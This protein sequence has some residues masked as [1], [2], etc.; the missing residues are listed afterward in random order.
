MNIFHQ[1]N[2]LPNELK[3]DEFGFYISINIF[4]KTLNTELIFKNIRNCKEKEK[5][6]HE[7]RSKIGTANLMH[8]SKVF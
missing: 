7:A 1:K 8:D 4:F 5:K 3:F 2:V 6:I